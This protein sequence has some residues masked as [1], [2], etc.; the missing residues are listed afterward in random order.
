MGR[1]ISNLVG[2][3]TLDGTENDSSDNPTNGVW[4][5]TEQYGLGKQFTQ[6]GDFTGSNYVSVST[7]LSVQSVSFWINL[8]SNNTDLIDLTASAKISIDGSDNITT[9]G[10]TNVT[11]YVDN[12]VTSSAGTGSY[13]LIILT[14]DSISA[15][16]IKLGDG[17]DG[18]IGD[19][20]FYNS[21]LTEQ[22]RFSI[23]NNGNGNKYNDFTRI[24]YEIQGNNLTDF[25]VASN[26]NIDLNTDDEV[27]SVNFE[28]LS[29]YPVQIGDVLNYYDYRNTFIFSGLVRDIQNNTISKSITVYSYEILMSDR[30]VNDVF[31]SISPEALIQ[32]LIET[33]TSLTYISTYS[34]GLTIEKYVSKNKTVRT[35]IRDI[36]KRL[37]G[38]TY[39][40]NK[41]REFDLFALGSVTS[42]EIFENG[43]NV[44]IN[45]GWSQD[46]SKQVTRL[47]LIGDKQ[48]PFTQDS[49]T[50]S[51]SQ[52]IFTLTEIPVGNIKVSVNGTEK[53]LQVDG[54]TSGDY[55]LDRENKTVT[56]ISPLSGG[57][58]V[59]IDYSFELNISVEQDADIEI[60]NTYGVIE[61]EVTRKFLNTMEDAREFAIEYL[62]NFSVP[63]LS[64][65]P[66][67]SDNINYDNLRPG[68]QIK[69]IDTINEVN[70]SNIDDF[71]IIRKIKRNFGNETSLIVEVGDETNPPIKFFQESNYNLQQLYE[72]DN[73]STFFQKSQQ[74]INNVLIE[75]D[76]D[77]TKI[78]KKVFDSDTFYL[79]ENA[80]GTRNQMKEDG[81]GPV[82]RE[83]G[84]TPSTLF[85]SSSP[86]DGGI[87]TNSFQTNVKTNF[88]NSLSNSITHMGVGDDNTTPLKTDTTLGNETYRES[89]FKTNSGPDF[90]FW[91]LRLDETENNGNTIKEV[92]TFDASSG[93][94]LYTRNLTTSFDKTNLKQAYYSV[95][96]IT[97]TKVVDNLN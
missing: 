32:Q 84:F 62:S 37:P 25:D 39:Y 44:N 92:G 40:V 72:Q 80:S 88:L 19:V 47:N 61:S 48:T 70:G 14:F 43:V 86:T 31:V 7:T 35:V 12:T 36:L 75:F 26:S 4:N 8:D 49:F 29:S 15:D 83:T 52:T 60:L 41:D 71:Y 73:N 65:E 34:S 90:I 21:L 45:G 3:W 87:I 69:V 51:A 33:Y 59:V 2:W 82:M 13:K 10:L 93:G 56:F 11:T 46:T 24:L 28:V 30:I 68:D 67:K 16:A 18:R 85:S 95:K 27:D 22:E 78:E 77:I 1:Q 54:Q 55:T 89:I 81:S 23:W 57:E 5:G 97:T 79:E 64:S 76:I 50:A 63:L 58:S 91:D 6:A 66:R 74:F 96:I 9:T 38:I 53:V 17:T 94:N 20:R 42:S